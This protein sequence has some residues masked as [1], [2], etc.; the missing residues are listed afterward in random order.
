MAK[1]SLV[2]TNECTSLITLC[3]IPGLGLT[4][5]VGYLDAT[6]TYVH[7]HLSSEASA[8]EV[9]LASS[10]S[11]HDAKPEFR[12]GKCSRNVG[13]F[14]QSGGPSRT[15]IYGGSTWRVD[16][17]IQVSCL[18][19]PSSNRPNPNGEHSTVLY[20]V[21]LT[22]CDGKGPGVLYYYFINRIFLSST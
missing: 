13:R 3:R 17:E 21:P 7:T 22:L 4:D 6:A 11:S 10:N 19:H 20:V 12:C 14:E 1:A 8:S 2:P 18:I 9:G 5:C 15:T 16:V